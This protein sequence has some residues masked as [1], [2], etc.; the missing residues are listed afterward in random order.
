MRRESERRVFLLLAVVAFAL[1]AL[2]A[3]MMLATGRR[4]WL[5]GVAANSAGFLLNF[6]QYFIRRAGR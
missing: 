6:A 1:V 5:I 3:C 2:H 4:L